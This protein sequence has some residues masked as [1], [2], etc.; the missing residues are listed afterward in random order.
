MV[1]STI[2]RAVLTVGALDQS[3]KIAFAIAAA[4]FLSKM[5]LLKDPKLAQLLVLPIGNLVCKFKIKT[6]QSSSLQ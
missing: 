2:F 1:F 6:T 4:C 3:N 5:N